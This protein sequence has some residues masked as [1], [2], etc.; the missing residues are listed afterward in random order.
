LLLCFVLFFLVLFVLLCVCVFV[1]FPRS[2]QAGY[3]DDASRRSLV[4]LCLMI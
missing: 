3:G 2:L 1:C 4:Y